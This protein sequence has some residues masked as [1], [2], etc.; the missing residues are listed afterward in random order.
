MADVRNFAAGVLLDRELPNADLAVFV[1]D[2]PAD[3]NDTGALKTGGD[4]AVQILLAGDVQLADDVQPQQQADFER[5]VEGLVVDEERR[6]IVKL[7][8]ADRIPVDAVVDVL[9]GLLLHER[10][11]VVL[12]Q[13]RKS[14]T[15]VPQDLGV[16]LLAVV[17]GGTTAEE[18]GL[19]E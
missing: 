12:P 13:F 10:R 16:I 7:V 19:G 11:A 6:R 1:W 8:G 18:L 9:A 2:P 5:D 15:H 17:P 14:W 4:R 3:A